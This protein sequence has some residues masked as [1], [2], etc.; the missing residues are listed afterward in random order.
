MVNS[1]KKLVVKQYQCPVCKKIHTIKFEPD[2]AKNRV[3]YPFTFAFM[4][5]F[6]SPTNIEDHEKDVLTTLYIDTHLNI[7]GV[8]AVLADDNTN[9]LSKETSYE[10]ITKLT[11]VILEMQN[12]LNEIQE[13]Y[14]ALKLKCE[15]ANIE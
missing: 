14:T 5:K 9:I 13:K 12:E 11:K 6:E 7:R 4:H 8:E 1:S 3:K 10:M 2:F 15:Q